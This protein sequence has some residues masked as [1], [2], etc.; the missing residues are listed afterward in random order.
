MISKDIKLQCKLV[1]IEDAQ[2]H[3][4]EPIGG[5]SKSRSQWW[6]DADTWATSNLGQG[7]IG[8]RPKGSAWQQDCRWLVDEFRFWFRDP[9][10]MFVFYL[11]LTP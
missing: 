7:F 11:A 10:D 2:W 5:T 9:E 4:V 1:Q 6:D 3:T 8:V